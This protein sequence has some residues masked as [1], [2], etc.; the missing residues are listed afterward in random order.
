[1]AHAVS[2]TDRS[3]R[4]SV[5]AIS[6][7]SPIVVQHLQ[8]HAPAPVEQRHKAEGM[9]GLSIP[10]LSPIEAHTLSTLSN[11]P[12]SRGSGNGYESSR[13]PPRGARDGHPRLA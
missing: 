10:S 13:G 4:I 7:Q 2:V 1:M 11:K 5:V 12:M 6:R 3:R 8:Q 9:L